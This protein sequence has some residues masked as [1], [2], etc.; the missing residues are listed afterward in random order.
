MAD[1]KEFDINK[2]KNVE[3]MD[4]KDRQYFEKYGSAMEEQAEIIKENIKENCE[5]KMDD[6]IKYA[7]EVYD[8]VMKRLSGNMH[9]YLVHGACLKCS[10]QL[11]EGKIQKLVH[12]EDMIDSKAD[13]MEITSKL[14]ILEPRTE[15]ANGLPFANVSDTRGGLSGELLKGED[16]E[17]EEEENQLNFISFGNCGFLDEEGIT[18]VEKIAERV[19]QILLSD[20][21]LGGN[22]KY[23]DITKEKILN[24][25]LEGIESGKG[26]C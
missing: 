5:E 23:N 19:L 8:D 2:I 11:E 10:K 14:R 24:G 1:D 3:F 4:A 26:S 17:G 7:N 16:E 18:D 12:E 22:S 20:S 6:Y 21:D 25:I 15:S 13:Y 9:Q